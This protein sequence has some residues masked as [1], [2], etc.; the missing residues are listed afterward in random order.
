MWLGHPKADLDYLQDLLWAYCDDYTWVMSA[1][2]F[3]VNDLGS[4]AR[5]ARLAEILFAFKDQ[6]ENEVSDRVSA[7]IDR[8]VFSNVADP[9]NTEFWHTAR[10]NWNHVCN[11]SVI[12]AALLLIEDPKVLAQFI[13]PMIQNM[14][15]ALDG[16]TDDGGCEE[17]AGYWGYGFGHYVQAAHALHCRTGGELNIMSDP[18]VEKICRYP[19]ASHIE[20][21]CRASFADCGEGSVAPLV[22]LQINKFYK[23]P[24]LFELCSRVPAETGKGARVG[25]SIDAHRIRPGALSGPGALDVRDMHSLA[26]FKGE[27]VTGR[28]D[29]KDYLLPDLGIVKLRGKPEAKQMTLIA[30]AGHNGVPHNHNDIGSFHLY[31]G[32]RMLMTDPGAPM[33]NSQTFGDRRYEI[34]W[35]RSKGHSVPIINGRAILPDR[36]IMRRCEHE[37]P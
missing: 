3:A 24:E 8:R 35:C 9:R 15:Y 11:G 27:K 28:A 4:T 21:A 16:F 37:P 18:K 30:L 32:G 33:Y 34:L 19:L 10:M 7:E 36:M 5:A 14:T 6:I 2:I 23:I 13:H 29:N 12:R 31:R 26:L 22:A 25:D 1:H 17:G 20:G